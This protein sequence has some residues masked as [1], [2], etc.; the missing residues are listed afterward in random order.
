MTVAREAF[1]TTRAGD[2]VDR[3]VLAAGGIEVALIALG[4]SIQAL[5]AADREGR[6]ANVVLGFE[7]VADYERHAGQHLGGTIGRY[8]NRIAGGTFV[9]DGTRYRIPPNDGTNALHG[10]EAGFDTHVW[11]AVVRPETDGRV[12][13]T[14]GRTSPSGEM[15]FPGALSVEVTY[16]LS[17]D[18]RLRLDY[19]A[20][21]DAPTVVN[22]TNHAYWNL[23]G[24]GSGSILDHEL[25]VAADRFLPVDGSL[26]PTGEPAQVAGTPFDFRE[27]CAIG[28]RIRAGSA[29]LVLARGYD[30][31]YV[32]DRGSTS[33]PGL[34]ARVSDPGSGRVL[35]VATTEP[36]LQVYS[37]NFLDGTLVG[38]SGRAY[39]QS[40]GFALETQHFP[41]SPNQPA[42]PST[43]LRPG[44]VFEST[45]IYRLGTERA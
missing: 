44:E 26:I 40:D 12:G 8:A 14:F 28:E 17:A 13:V 16:S 39:R 43:V 9:L 18:G 29:Q 32:L 36:G 25:T 6:L 20:E 19:R 7:T 27:P 5:R 1:G 35:E 30:H 24:E 23:A 4:A 3:Y 33:E 37:G 10:G 2:Q 22:L 41:D 11:D 21:T 34:A 31:T 42:F 15:G 38:A 45:T